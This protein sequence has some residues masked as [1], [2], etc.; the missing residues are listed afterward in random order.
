M[1]RRKSVFKLKSHPLRKP[2]PFADLMLCPGN[3]APSRHPLPPPGGEDKGE[4]GAVRILRIISGAATLAPA[5][6]L[7]LMRAMQLFSKDLLKR[8]CLDLSLL[9]FLSQ[10]HIYSPGSEQPG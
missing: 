6:Y 2:V 4:G 10:I 1:M 9:R 5:S 8:S 3:S 7:L